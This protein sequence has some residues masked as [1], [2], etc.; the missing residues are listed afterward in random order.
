MTSDDSRQRAARTQH[1]LFDNAPESQSFCEPPL[2]QRPA[3]WAV[4][5]PKEP[6]ALPMSCACCGAPALSQ[7]SLA[8]GSLELLIPYC[9]ACV[10]HVASDTTRALSERLAAAI[11]GLS[12]CFALPVFLPWWPAPLCSL[13]SLAVAALPFAQRLVRRRPRAP[14]TA[15]G[16]AVWFGA[17]GELSCAS[18]AYA[19]ALAEAF[20]ATPEARQPARSFTLPLAAAALLAFVLAPLA[21]AYQHPSV[22]VL[23]LHDLP[24]ELSVDGRPVARVEPSSGESPFAGVELNLPAGR[25]TLRARDV[26]GRLVESVEVELLAGAHHLYA[27]A[28]PETCFWLETR[29]YGRGA[30]KTTYEPLLGPIPFWAIPEDVHGWFLPGSEASAESRV[31]GGSARA[32]RQGPCEAAPFAH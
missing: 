31:T 3:A 20:G 9:D 16:P 12:A 19:R 10:A 2:G 28:S 14:H 13:V 4:A 25:R 17:R 15:R 24:F 32:L 6:R 22:R 8:K 27:P 7:L 5:L 21:H 1:E 23:N 29:G 26:E 30:R 11:A 18:P